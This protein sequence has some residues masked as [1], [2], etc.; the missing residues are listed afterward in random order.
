MRYSG[1]KKKSK[2]ERLRGRKRKSRIGDGEPD[3]FEEAEHE[4]KKQAGLLMV[5]GDDE[6]VCWAE[7]KC[8]YT[9][10]TSEGYLCKVC[11]KTKCTACDGRVRRHN[12]W[13]CLE[14]DNGH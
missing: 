8:C 7:V 4:A 12:R 10:G 9:C 1:R 5:D 14:C 3:M 2:G 13:V 6:D 11:I